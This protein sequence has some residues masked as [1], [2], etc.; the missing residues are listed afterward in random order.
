MTPSFGSWILG[1][2][3]AGWIVLLSVGWIWKSETVQL[4]VAAVNVALT[5][6]YAATFVPA[7]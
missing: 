3:V 6:L 2:M 4:A 1:L 7:L 5:A